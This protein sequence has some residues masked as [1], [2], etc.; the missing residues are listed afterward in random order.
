MTLKY[1]FEYT[2]KLDDLD[3]QGH[4]GNA[5]WLILLQRA[6]IDLCTE[7]GYPFEEMTKSGVGGVVAEANLKYYY[8]AFNDDVISINVVLKDPKENSLILRHKCKNQDNKLCLVSDIKLVFVDKSGKPVNMPK[9]FKDK[10][11]PEE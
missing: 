7:M 10:L 5:N 3:Y 4:V 11:F 1:N 6:R 9:Q 8:P 2:I